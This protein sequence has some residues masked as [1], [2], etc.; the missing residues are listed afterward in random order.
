MMVMSVTV[1]RPAPTVL[2]GSGAE[3][4]NWLSSIPVIRT[5]SGDWGKPEPAET[6]LQP[7]RRWSVSELA[8]LWRHRELLGFLALRDIKVRYKQT[9]LGAFWAVLQ[10]VAMMVALTALRTIMGM[11]GKQIPV[12]I[13]AALLP[14]TFFS[15]SVTA[16]T[17]SLVT[18]A[19]MLR[20]I[21]F[22]RL[23]VPVAAV[24]A[25]MLDYTISFAVLAAMMWWFQV[26]FTWEL[27]F[28]PLLIFST[29]IAALGVGVMLSALTVKYRDFRY[30]VTLLV[31]L[32]FF[33]T[34][35]IYCVQEIP[36]RYQWMMMLNPMGGTIEAFRAVVL[37]TPIDFVAWA[38]SAQVAVLCL[39]LGLVYFHRAERKFA[40]VV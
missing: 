6:V 19:H 40:D 36:L 33:A 1:M 12:F 13:F 32:W 17:N 7:R 26:A 11:G 30:V 8:K 20:K 18:N 15:A 2:T 37:G 39:L 22:P 35:V 31:Q 16:S 9:L 29:V 38:V 4:A 5:L 25:P 27:L 34:P 24:G 28:L 23:I 14:W 10:P 3:G 21:Y